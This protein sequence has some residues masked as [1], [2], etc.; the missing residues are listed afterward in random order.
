MSKHTDYIKHY[1]NTKENTYCIWKRS[2]FGMFGFHDYE[3]VTTCGKSY[4]CD[5]VLKEK[6][7]PNCGKL[8]K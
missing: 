6:Y 8:I 7:C 2:D 1:M 4:D 3:Y 5:K